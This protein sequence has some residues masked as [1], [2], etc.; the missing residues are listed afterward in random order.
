[1]VLGWSCED[2]GPISTAHVSS[3]HSWFN[4]IA[5]LAVFVI[6]AVALGLGAAALASV[7]KSVL[8]DVG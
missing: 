8:E 4:T 6:A 7:W 1:M 2:D 5:M 3:L